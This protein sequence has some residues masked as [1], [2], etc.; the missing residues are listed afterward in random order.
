[1]H[2]SFLTS[3]AQYL[4]EV[5]REAYSHPAVEGIIIF[6]GPAPAG[7]YATALTDMSFNNTPAGDV[8]DKLIKEWKPEDLK[9]HTDEGGFFG[10]SL[11]HGEYEITVINP[12][13]NSS[14][15]SRFEVTKDSS[16]K[17]F[18]LQME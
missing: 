9:A 16:D 18:H 14:S 3:Q 13:T 7:F 15:T 11:L 5:L 17:I 10:T 2:N 12:I 4:E 1:M 6:A 8:V